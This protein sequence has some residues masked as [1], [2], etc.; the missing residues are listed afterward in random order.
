MPPAAG[1]VNFSATVK[2]QRAPP[3]RLQRALA[4]AP[5]AWRHRS[6]SLPPRHYGP[7]WRAPAENRRG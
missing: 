4:A 5:A 7:P 3:A 2:P 1:H 6:L